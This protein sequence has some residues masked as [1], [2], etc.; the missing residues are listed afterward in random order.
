MIGSR[1][2]SIKVRV[3]GATVL[4]M[5]SALET[6]KFLSFP[7]AKKIEEQY[8]TPVYVY[9]EKMLKSQAEKALAFP[10]MYGLTVRFAMKACPNKAIVKLFNEMGINF[11]A[12]SGFE[13][14]RMIKAGIHPNKISLSS[15]EL[16]KNFKE[17]KELGI[18]F[19]ACSQSQL[20]KFGKLFP[21]GSC[22]VRFNPGRGSGGTGKTN[23]GGSSSSFGI[24]YEQLDQIKE[25]VTMY[26]IDVTRIHTHIGSGSDPKIWQEVSEKSLDL[27]REFTGVKTLNLGGGYK[28]G[29]MAGEKSTDLQVVGSPVKEN[30]KKFF[31]ETGREIK[32]EI[33]PGTFLVANAGVLLT[34]VQDVVT[35]K[36]LSSP[37][38]G[39]DFIKL[40]SGMTEVLRPS[41]Y[42][43]Q[44]PLIVHKDTSAGTE[45]T[46]YVVVGHCC[47]SGD[48][49][50]CKPG[51][52]ESLEERV[53][54]TV[55][56]GDL[57][58]IGGSG[59]Y[60]SSMSTKGYN[61]FP[62]APEVMIKGSG[63]LQ[64]IRRR[65]TLDQMLENEL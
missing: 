58:E 2:A 13:V 53:L 10:N 21:G 38:E 20:V 3:R 50:T 1:T 12:S 41:L 19:N 45:T 32:L 14:S 15:Q 49:F 51:D 29:R 63:E 17:L 7:T 65:Q 64:L 62:E 59:A 25:I 8:Q 4:A 48:L 37:E 35:T 5:S 28:V 60:C 9:D 23:V 34:K 52:P 11:D 43:A 42:G 33:E 40:D 56:I 24:W 18:E 30:F 22:G 54:L 61:S 55:E 16:P 26:N 36:G 44:H 57:I 27:V 39:R 6:S 46:P 31:E 47:E